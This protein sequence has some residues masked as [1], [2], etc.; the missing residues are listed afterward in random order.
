MHI[1]LFQI[2]GWQKDYATKGLIEAGFSV[3]AFQEGID[4][5]SIKD[6]SQYEA[7]SVFVGPAVNKEIIDR[8]PNLKLIATRSTGFDHIDL[9]YAK[10][11]GITVCSVPHYG[12]NTVAEFA[13]GLILTLTRKLY[14]GIDR[15]KESN[16]FNFDGLEGMDLKGKVLGVVGTGSIGRNVI[17]M[18]KGFSMTIIGYDPYPNQE[19]AKELGFSYAETLEE[20]LGQA[21][22]IT[23][24]VPY[25]PATH[26]L[27]NSNTIEAIKRGAFLINT[28]RGPVVETQALVVA[29]QKGILAGAGLDVLEEEEVA[30][31]EQ[32]FWMRDADDDAKGINLRTVLQNSVLMDMPNV[33]ITPHNAFN[34]KE[35]KIR[36][37]DT[38]IEN[39]KQFAETGKPTFI[40]EQK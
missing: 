37:L 33:I 36:I 25:M 27:I 5:A 15:I 9:A 1:A 30:K 20:L 12:E 28:A 8:F 21:D 34:T 31:D 26:H 22:I 23:L 24:H 40:V 18:A 39:I 3:D 19:A 11:K 10:E 29:L 6:S 35:A 2:D 4:K 16:E 32:G 38:D 7:I 13:M 14:W 17:Q